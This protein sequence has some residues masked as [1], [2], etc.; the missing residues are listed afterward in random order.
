MV[1]VSRTAKSFSDAN[2]LHFVLMF[3]SYIILELES[4][5]KSLYHNMSKADYLRVAT[6]QAQNGRYLE[7]CVSDYAALA[8][9]LKDLY[10]MMWKLANADEARYIIE[11]LTSN[12]LRFAQWFFYGEGAREPN[13]SLLRTRLNFELGRTY[14]VVVDPYELSQLLYLDLMKDNWAKLLTFNYQGSIY[15]W[16]EEIGR[17]LLSKQLT[18]L[19]HT[20]HKVKE[21]TAGNTR[22]RG[23]KRA[24]PDKA[25]FIIDECVHAKR[26]QEV[27]YLV[28]VDKLTE[29]DAAIR[30]G[31]SLEAFEAEFQQACRRLRDG[32]LRS[33]YNFDDV[34][35]DKDPRIVKVTPD[36]SVELARWI[37][38]VTRSDYAEVFGANAS[39]D[40]IEE[41]CLEVLES[42]KAHMPWS[43]RDRYIFAQRQAGRPALEIAKELGLKGSYIDNHYSRLRARY[44]KALR[45]WWEEWY[46]GRKQK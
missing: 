38:N 29:E 44:A 9:C 2:L 42:V 1:D 11:R 37:S 41:R 17:H 45:Q 31:I 22:L 3:V 8:A 5:Q 26:Y 14:N 33:L 35:S 10:E 39:N 40:E 4:N 32:V 12:D 6:L 19:G 25:R 30:L 46:N 34:L 13:I 24:D 23:L 16:L 15:S 43:E 27:L 21:R 20:Q 7:K 18:L 28:F 36:Y